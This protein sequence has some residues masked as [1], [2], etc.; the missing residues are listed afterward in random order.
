MCCLA[1]VSAEVFA[2]AA[3]SAA[4]VSQ[5]QHRIWW[6]SCCCLLGLSLDCC[7]HNHNHTYRQYAWLS[8]VL[9]PSSALWKA[10]TGTVT[11]MESLP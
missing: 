10:H 4:A 6:T 2:A 11:N 7:I 1:V 8:Y 3:D 5:Q 9:S